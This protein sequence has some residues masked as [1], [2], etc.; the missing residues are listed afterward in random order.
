LLLGLNVCDMMVTDPLKER[1]RRGEVVLGMTVRLARSADIALVAKSTG[2]DFLFIDAQHSI[3]PLEAIA[4]IAQVASGC[5][6]TPLVRVGSYDDATTSLL[7]DN[8]VA[9]IVFPDVETEEQAR[10]AVEVAKFAPIGKR[11]VCGG[12]PQFAYRAVPVDESTRMLNDATLVVCMIE[13]VRGLE[14][15]DAIASVSGVDVILV[16]SNDLLFSMGKPGKFGDPDHVRAVERI[17]AAARAHGKFAGLGGERNVERQVD[18][19]RKG[20]T[21][22]TTHTDIGF[23]MAEAS[24]QTAAVRAALG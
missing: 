8:G 19:I 17:I 4:N 13:T 9:G 2:H 12:Y 21:F 15:V 1:M 3:F 10:Y 5:G 11:S 7:L 18:F 23:L 16:G 6:V 20:V 22:V 14:N 24:R